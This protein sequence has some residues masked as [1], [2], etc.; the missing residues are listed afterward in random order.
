MQFKK[1]WKSLERLNRFC[2]IVSGSKEASQKLK[3]VSDGTNCKRSSVKEEYIRPI[4]NTL[5]TFVRSKQLSKLQALK[6]RIL[7]RTIAFW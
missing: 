7:K 5:E 3:M 4:N 1:I 6:R 2:V